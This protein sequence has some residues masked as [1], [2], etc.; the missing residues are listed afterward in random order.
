MTKI[1]LFTLL[2][3]AMF[4]TS[5][6]ANTTSGKCGDNLTWEVTGERHNYVLTISGTGAMY[7]FD[8]INDVVRRACPGR[9]SDFF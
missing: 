9:N 3:A 1:K 2:A 6:W 7:D 5:M 4:A 8:R